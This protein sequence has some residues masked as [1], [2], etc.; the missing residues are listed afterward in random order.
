MKRK[1]EVDRSVQ[2]DIGGHVLITVINYDART[3]AMVD[4][5]KDAQETAKELLED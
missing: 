1:T 5:V 4:S 2:L 3:R